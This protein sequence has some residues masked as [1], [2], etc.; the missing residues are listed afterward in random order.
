MGRERRKYTRVVVDISEIRGTMMP[1]KE[2][3]IVDLSIGGISVKSDRR[4]SIGNEYAL[5]IKDK[6]RVLPLKGLVVSSFLSESRKKPEGGVEPVYTAG[7]K[8]TDITG[9][10]TAQLAEF[11]E[12]HRQETTIPKKDVDESGPG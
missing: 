9:E 11:I 7:I 5:E 3:E 6:E 8:F 10:M 4:L 1:A 2:V 12:R